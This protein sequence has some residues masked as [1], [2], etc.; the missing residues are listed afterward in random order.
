[1]KN[2][3]DVSV[4][5]LKGNQSKVYMYLN[6]PALGKAEHRKNVCSPLANDMILLH[7]VQYIII[8]IERS[9]V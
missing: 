4:L 3:K 8:D 5:G 1:M 6:S 9:I 7:E 2:G